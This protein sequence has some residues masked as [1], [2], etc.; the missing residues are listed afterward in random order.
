MTT[1]NKVVWSE[2][3]FL[4]PQHFQQHDRYLEQLVSDSISSIRPHPWGHTELKINQEALKLGQ[5]ALNFASGVMPDGTPFKMPQE[6]DAPASIPVPESVKN[7]VIYLALPI[8]QPGAYEYEYPGVQETA[9]RYVVHESEARDAIT[10]SDASVQME[11]GRLRFTFKFDFEDLDG[12]I[13]LP[14]ARVIEV[15]ADKQVI[16]DDEYISTCLASHSS[17]VL[18]GY[19]REIWGMLSHRADALAGRV[20]NSGS[21][22]VAE[23]SDFLLLQTVNR[24]EP[25]YAHFAQTPSL[26]PEALY[27]ISIQLVGELATFTAAARRPS[28]LQPYRH[29]A[30]TESF[31]PV[32]AH[33]RQHLSAVLEQTAVPIPLEER[34]YGVRVGMLLDRSLIKSARFVLAVSADLPSEVINRHFPGQITIGSVEQIRDFVNSALAG[35]AV[36]QLPVA[37]RQIPYHTGTAYF[38]LDPASSHWDEIRVSGGLALHVAGDFPKLVMELWA[39]REQ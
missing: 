16:L 4:Q 22:G 3:L 33:L 31:A 12:W 11:T 18:Y 26:H 34:K 29:E 36:K 13:C 37:P 6:C 5:F 39:I 7:S 30:L 21:K 28:T 19:I 2:G 23:I 1:H 32:I 8:R 14:I 24:Y 35:I 10:G 15:R 38:E 27:R 17:S 25:L 9:A 20:S